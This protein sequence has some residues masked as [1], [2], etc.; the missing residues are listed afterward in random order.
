M[1]AATRASCWPLCHAET[2]FTHAGEAIVVTDLRH[3]I[4]AVNPVFSEMFRAAHSAPGEGRLQEGGALLGATLEATGLTWVVQPGELGFN[5]RLERDGQ[6]RSEVSWRDA[7]GRRRHGVISG[8]RVSA[9]GSLGQHQVLVLTDLSALATPPRLLRQEAAGGREVYFDTLTG[10]PNQQLV[11]QLIEESVRHAERSGGRLAL[12]ALDIDHFKR[13]NDRLG[14]RGGDELLATFA[15]RITHLLGGDDVVARVGGDE[16]VLLLHAAQD[17]RLFG[18]LLEAMQQPVSIAGH[19]VRVTASLGVTCYPDDA[20]EG[21]VLLRHATQA[22]Y[23]AKQ[24]GRNTFH[25]FDPQQDRQLQ[26]RQERRRRLSQGLA[27]DE[28]C[29]YYQPQVDMFGGRVVGVEAL[30]RWRH[31]EEGLLP[32]GAFLPVVEGSEL[33]VPL[34]EWVIAAALRQLAAWQAE[35]VGLP[36][37]V[38]I[39]PAHLLSEGFAERL[40]TALARHPE[41]SPRLLKLEILESAAIHDVQAALGVMRHCQALGIDFAMDDFGTGFSSLTHLRQLPVDLIKIDQSFVR[42]MLNDPDD[43][44]IVES[45]IFM[46]NRFKKPMLA[47]GVETL[48]HARALVR[49]GCSLAQGYG[50]ARPMPAEALPEWL[51]GWAN[52]HEWTALSLQIPTA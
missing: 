25:R 48:A 44:A 31:P 45:V 49:L 37:H 2:G 1:T 22:M 4:L 6:A 15:Q 5:A 30:L 24:R 26:L 8:R 40:E 33:E 12:C 35:S 27:A 46:A 42:N 20:V 21:D 41:V 39:S 52:R 9:E 14:R 11:T 36:I 13:H 34:G 16:F 18:R 10:L 51:K 43:L 38:N 19:S 7:E 32:P 17:D 47:E 23:R 50:I 3:R 29:L 28:L